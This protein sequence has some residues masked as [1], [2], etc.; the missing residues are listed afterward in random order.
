MSGR[1]DKTY[2]EA[3]FCIF[4]IIISVIIAVGGSDFSSPDFF[5]A[6]TG[7]CPYGVSPGFLFIDN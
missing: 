1:C 5:R 4:I 7:F 3:R 6:N 2:D